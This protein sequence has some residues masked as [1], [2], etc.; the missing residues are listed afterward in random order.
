MILWFERHDTFSWFIAVIIAIGIFYI[1]SLSFA[2]G[3]GGEHD[4]KATA[5]HIGVFLLFSFFLLI[6][7]VRGKYGMFVLPVILFSIAYGLSDELHQAFTPGRY[8]SFRDVML[9][10]LGIGISS[11]FYMIT[12]RYRGLRKRIKK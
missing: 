7:I 9:D 10:S 2:G 4:L 3:I 8:P 6:S 12:L 5:Y 11:V 1:S